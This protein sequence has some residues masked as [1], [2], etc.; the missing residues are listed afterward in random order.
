MLRRI[1]IPKRNKSCF[2]NSVIH[3]TRW[4]RPKC[5]SILAN[6]MLLDE[7]WKLYTISHPQAETWPS[8][9]VWSLDNERKTLQSPNDRISDSSDKRKIYE[10]SF[11]VNH[12]QQFNWRLLM[13][14]GYL[15]YKVKDLWYWS[16]RKI[17]KTL[18]DIAIFLR[19]N[20]DRKR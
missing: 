10:N 6:R 9:I 11:R 14:S 19:H 20:F 1:M 8:F 12:L 2:S 13:S 17:S 16:I 4:I 7:K 5:R 18:G 15:S 3:L